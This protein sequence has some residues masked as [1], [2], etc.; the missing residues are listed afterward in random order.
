[1]ASQQCVSF[2]NL[3]GNTNMLQLYVV[4]VKVNT[5]KPSI[6]SS[7]YNEELYRM[8]DTNENA[9]WA[10]QPNN[11]NDNYVYIKKFNINIK[12]YVMHT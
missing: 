3:S 9:I 1:M 4:V 11:I 10:K 7:T 5:S 8:A 12:T 6:P 2:S